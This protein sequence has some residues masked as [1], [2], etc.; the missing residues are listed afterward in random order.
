MIISEATRA[1]AR[2]HSRRAARS[3]ECRRHRHR[4]QGERR[5]AHRR[6]RHRLLGRREGARLRACRSRP[7]PPSV[8]GFPTDVVA[9]GEIR[10]LRAPTE[11]WRPAAGRREHRPR[12]LSPQARSAASCTAA[13]R[14]SCS[15]TTTCSPAR[16]DG[17]PGDA[18]LQPGPID[19]GTLPTASPR[20]IASCASRWP[21]K[22]ARARSR[23]VSPRRST[24]SPVLRAAR[25]ALRSREPGRRPRTSSTLPPPG[26]T[27]PRRSPRRSSASAPSPVRPPPNWACAC[28]RAAARPG[29][30]WARSSR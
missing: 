27:T 22:R 21:A 16:N 1:R 29:S 10:A 17:A 26:R 23:R 9:T 5:C 28:A 14:S 4:L 13:K 6:A 18:I 3:R 11:R 8:G 2:V 7:R 12:A 25:R 15:R 24:L 30:P 20:S 19:G